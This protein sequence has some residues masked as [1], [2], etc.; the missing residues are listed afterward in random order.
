MKNPTKNPGRAAV[1]SSVL[2]LATYVGVTVIA[3][4]VAGTGADG[5]GLANEENTDDVLYPGWSSSQ[6]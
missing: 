4:M 2:L 3:M 1:L 5:T 6:S